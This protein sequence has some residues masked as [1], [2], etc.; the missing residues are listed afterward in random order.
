MPDAA[1][2]LASESREQD[3][4][5]FA[6]S[7]RDATVGP[8]R[9]VPRTGYTLTRRVSNS[10][11]CFRDDTKRRTIDLSCRKQVHSLRIPCYKCVDAS[12]LCVHQHAS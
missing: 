11:R 7:P 9:R 3:R 5:V 6:L 12:P 2:L 10:T 4:L 1:A 8:L